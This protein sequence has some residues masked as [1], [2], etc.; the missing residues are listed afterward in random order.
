[1]KVLT[2]QAVLLDL[3]NG[4]HALRMWLQECL[5]FMNSCYQLSCTIARRPGQYRW[6][7]CSADYATMSQRASRMCYQGALLW[8]RISTYNPGQNSFE[9][10]RTNDG[11]RTNYQDCH[12][13]TSSPLPPPDQCWF[14]KWNANL[15]WYKWSSTLIWGRGGGNGFQF[16]KIYSMS[17]LTVCQ[18]SQWFWPGLS[19]NGISKIIGG[20]P[21]KMVQ[22]GGKHRLF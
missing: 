13:K 4:D 18:L 22:N 20:F 5:S 3:K 1:M 6:M 9:H 16:T 15:T 8:R 11:N 12:R 17:R 19:E 14:E 7:M 21:V 10:L 2:N